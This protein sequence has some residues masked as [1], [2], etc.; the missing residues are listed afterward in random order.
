MD[1]VKD[2]ENRRRFRRRL[3]IDDSLTKL[4]TMRDLPII[5][6]DSC[7]IGPPELPSLRS[8]ANKRRTSPL[9]IDDQ[10][11]SP[12]RSPAQTTV[13]DGTGHSAALRSERRRRRDHQR[14]AS[15]D[16]GES[17]H[18]EQSPSSRS[19]IGGRLRSTNAETAADSQTNN[20]LRDQ[21]P[22]AVDETEVS[23]SVGD[24]IELVLLPSEST[25]SDDLSPVEPD[26]NDAPRWPVTLD[27]EV[28][29]GEAD[30]EPW[31]HQLSSIER[32]HASF[33]DGVALYRRSK[34]SPAPVK[35]DS[36]HE[37][38]STAAVNAAKRPE[39][40]SPR[41]FVPRTP[42][43]FRIYNDSLPAAWQPQTPQNLPEARHQSRLRGAFTVPSR[44]TGDPARTPTSG[45]LRRRLEGRDPSPTGLRRPG[46]T[47]LYGGVENAD[48]SAAFSRTSGT[49]GTDDDQILSSPSSPRQEE[50]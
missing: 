6:I 50:S 13:E 44:Y 29:E 5:N 2:L 9:R 11:V 36:E 14:L 25:P 47:G 45:R 22:P 40:R 33:M 4:R 39:D 28:P 17:R 34:E 16:R 38:S 15:L 10:N 41:F 19:S 24:P 26:R 30:H 49:M 8:P 27:A 48:D 1:E 42:N 31:Q 23:H 32:A 37:S 20:T 21:L 35:R 43:R 12:S 46:F 18:V 7:C 3:E